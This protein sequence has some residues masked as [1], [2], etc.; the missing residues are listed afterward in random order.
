M[1]RLIEFENLRVRRGACPAL[2]GL[3]LKIERGENVAIIGPNGSG[4]ST[5]IKTITREIYPQADVFRIFGAETWNIFDLKSRLGI[6][7]PDLQQ[8]FSRDVTGG[9]AVLSGFFSAV[10]LCWQDKVTALMKRKIRR[11]LAFLGISRLERRPMTAMS[12]GEAR[13]VLIARAL[14]HRPEAL[15][16]DE[17]T[18]SLD[19][20]A[21]KKLTGTLRRIAASGKNL[22]L[23]THHL[24]D[25][26]PEIK[27]VIL[28]KE[29]RV[30]RDG[31]KETVMTEEN[32]RS[33]FGVP[34][35]LGRRGGFY[36][37]W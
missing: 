23:V 2:R 22:I 27:R 5:L 26:I 9:E 28:L 4:K 36:H 32:L 30:F 7:T 12:S 11:A 16:L 19:I 8:I 31:P 35:R 13:R 14:V 20:G 25:V 33:L 18:T 24:H 3:S 10:E 37:L 6:V 1:P 29:G 15:V 34:V 21:Q 17:P